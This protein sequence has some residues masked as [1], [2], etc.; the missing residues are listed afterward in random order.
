MNKKRWFWASVVAIA[1]MLAM[2]FF[3]NNHCLKGLYQQTAHLW[4]PEAEL[5]GMMMRYGWITYLVG[6]F[7]FAYI[8]AKGYE[9]K[10]SHVLEGV[11]FGFLMGLFSS[12]PMSI[13]TYIT[14]PIPGR[15][16]IDWLII[17]MF[18][19]IVAGAVVGLIYRK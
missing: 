15:L 6:G 17:G 11:R 1:V 4:R 16:S 10:P 8:Y 12:V 18:E 5:M 14:M 3:F 2:D 9:G 19:L 7:V 13:M